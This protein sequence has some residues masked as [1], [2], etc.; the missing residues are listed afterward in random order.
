M[1]YVFEPSQKDSQLGRARPV[2]VQLGTD[3]EG[4]VSVT[5]DLKAGQKVIVEGNERMRPPFEVRVTEQA[6]SRP[7]D[8]GGAARRPSVSGR[9]SSRSE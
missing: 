6:R 3:N 4:H 7:A 2:P 1:V 9:P 5:G 8:A